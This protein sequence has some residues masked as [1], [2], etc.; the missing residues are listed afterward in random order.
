MRAD[1]GV[2]TTLQLLLYKVL[3]QGLGCLKSA[4]SRDQGEK[5]RAESRVQTGKNTVDKRL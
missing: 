1:K 5:D 4:D 2:N 3:N